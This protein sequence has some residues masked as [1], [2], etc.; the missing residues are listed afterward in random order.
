MITDVEINEDLPF[1]AFSVNGL[2]FVVLYSCMET[3]TIMSPDAFSWQLVP[4]IAFG[5]NASF[6]CPTTFLAKLNLVPCKK[7]SLHLSTVLLRQDSIHN[8]PGWHNPRSHSF[9]STAKYLHVGSHEVTQLE[10]TSWSPVHS[11]SKMS[12]CRSS[13]SPVDAWQYQRPFRQWLKWCK[14]LSQSNDK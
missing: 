1:I 5:A 13:L 3:G 11:I 12:T 6:K 9:L 14:L 2:S 4:N 7:R 10:A 8:L